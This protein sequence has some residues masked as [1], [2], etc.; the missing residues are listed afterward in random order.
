MNCNKSSRGHLS[1]EEAEGEEEECGTRDLGDKTTQ[2]PSKEKP[3]FI[4][5]L[6]ED[7]LHL[8]DVETAREQDMDRELSQARKNS[9]DIHN[10]NVFSHLTFSSTAVPHTPSLVSEVGYPELFTLYCKV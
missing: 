4:E 1:L 2:Y 6:P 3:F 7:Q 8:T 9:I 5:I 10:K